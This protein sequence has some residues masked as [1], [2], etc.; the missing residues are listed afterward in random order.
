MKASIFE[1]RGGALVDEF[2]P[3]LGT[4]WSENANQAETL[5]VAI[6]L[7]SIVE[8]ARGWRNLGTPWK[9]SIALDVHGRVLG[10]PIMPHDFDNDRGELK[11]TARGGRM[12]FTRHSILP[13][14][15]MTTPL[16]LDNG[17]LN[18]VLDSHW[19][20]VD[21][22]TIA[23]KIGQLAC[24]WPG[25]DYPIIWPADRVGSADY[26]YPAIDRTKVD[27]AWS[28]L[29]NVQKGPDIRLR[30]E[31]D[32][33]DRFRWVFETG[34]EAT[35][36]LQGTDVFTWEVGQGSGIR[37][38]TN[39][40]RMGS[41][42]WAQGGRSNDKAL[43][44]MRYDP[45]LV[46][47]GFPLLELESDASVNT[48]DPNNLDA[49][50]AETMRTAAKPWEFWSFDVRADRAPFP[51]EYGPGSLIKVVVSEDTPITGGYIPPGTYDRRIAGLSGDLSTR[52]TIT[53]GE[54]YDA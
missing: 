42:A 39:P 10:G 28:D 54:V 45:L 38:R 35:P 29:S 2:E 47:A 41:L 44:R 40:T 36:R 21:L 49:S 6:N 20:G 16:T 26:T 50:N 32:G 4:T 30:L 34:T 52:I 24:S 8:G 48:A 27:D 17:E 14:A 13:L 22:G 15:A 43:V 1:T 9:H 46:D 31:H 7:R 19:S 5:D 3:K 18:T 53:C 51:Y 11:L 12:L 25:R 37:I 33:P 23:K